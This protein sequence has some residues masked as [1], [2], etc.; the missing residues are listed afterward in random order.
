[1]PSVYTQMGRLKKDLM[2]QY[3]GS[4]QTMYIL[5]FAWEKHC[6]YVTQF[7]NVGESAN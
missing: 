5:H 3:I 1:M 7:Y 6:T 4:A 2:L